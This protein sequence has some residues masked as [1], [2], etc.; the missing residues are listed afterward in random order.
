MA[1][2]PICRDAP[3]AQRRGPLAVSA[4]AASRWR[5]RAPIADRGGRPG[6]R[7]WSRRVRPPRLRQVPASRSR[8]APQDA[9]HPQ[10]A[11]RLE[12]QA[13]WTRQVQPE[14][15]VDQKRQRSRV[16]SSETSAVNPNGATPN[17]VADARAWVA[18]ACGPPR[19]PPWR[20]RSVAATRS[21]SSRHLATGL[22]GEAERC[23]DEP[24]LGS[25]R[26]V[27]TP[28][29]ERPQRAPHRGR[30]RRRPL[31]ARRRVAAAL[32]LGGG[33]RGERRAECQS[34]I[35]GPP[36]SCRGQR[37]AVRRA[38]RPA[39][40]ELGSGDA[41]GAASAAATAATA[42]EGPA[43]TACQSDRRPSRSCGSPATPVASDG[44]V[45]PSSAATS[46]TTGAE[47]PPS[48]RQRGRSGSRRCAVVAGRVRAPK[49][50]RPGRRSG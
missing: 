49:R 4:R 34:G 28:A 3:R 1:S 26:G 21:T 37:A 15:G 10:R 45:A 19:A 25:H 23:R 44:A 14:G 5:G 17:T 50:R 9:G 39:A 41:A 29:I 18:S 2:C 27:P 16:R 47:S 22:G 30:S 38:G 40:F 24:Y 35:A 31:G 20:S 8:C 6:G 33:G 48:L 12:Q 42:A 43:T 46:S 36:R 7:P 32:S 11:Q 13:R